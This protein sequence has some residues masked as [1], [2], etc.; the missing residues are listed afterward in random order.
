M[1]SDLTSATSTGSSAYSSGCRVGLNMMELESDWPPA[2]RSPSATAEPLPPPADQ[3][4][5]PCL[6]SRCRS[7]ALPEI[8]LH[9]ID[10]QGTGADR[11]N[12]ELER[13]RNVGRRYKTFNGA[14]NQQHWYAS[15]YQL[16]P[17]QAVRNKGI[18]AP[19]VSRHQHRL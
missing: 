7:A 15:H 4:R 6:S 8:G 13:R 10:C 14:G 17:K 11:G 5:D 3:A 19:Q 18:T 12:G 9:E 2:E 1:A 16:Y